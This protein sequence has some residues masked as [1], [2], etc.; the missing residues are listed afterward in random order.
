MIYQFWYELVQGSW[1][2]ARYH[3]DSW[4]VLTRHS[5]AYSIVVCHFLPYAKDRHT[6]I[7]YESIFD[8]AWWKWGGEVTSPT[9]LATGERALEG[10]ASSRNPMPRSF[11]LERTLRWW[12]FFHQAHFL[13]S[14]TV[15]VSLGVFFFASRG[16][17]IM[18][19]SALFYESYADGFEWGGW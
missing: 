12:I 17:A 19:A 1:F 15:I 9:M 13:H 5:S 7:I 4:R 8:R 10:S 6:S 11:T 14:I 16:A 18:R 2:R 3:T